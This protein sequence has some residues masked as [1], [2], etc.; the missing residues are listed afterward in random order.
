MGYKTMEHAV[1]IGT[2]KSKKQFEVNFS[3]KFYH[4]PEAVVPKNMLPVEY[5]AL[6]LPAGTFGDEDGCIRYYGK[7]SE[8]KIVK[9]DEITSLPSKNPEMSYYKARW[10]QTGRN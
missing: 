6:Y 9:R 8:T 3:E 5:I 10:I 2:V 1:L 7:I 4:I